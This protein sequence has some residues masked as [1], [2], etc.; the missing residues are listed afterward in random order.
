MHNRFLEKKT[1]FNKTENV[2]RQISEIRNILS[3]NRS[4]NPKV[5]IC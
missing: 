3:K 4:F 2:W 1:I 5:G